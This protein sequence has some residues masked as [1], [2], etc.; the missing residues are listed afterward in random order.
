MNTTSSLLGKNF[1]PLTTENEKLGKLNSQMDQMKDDYEE[2]KRTREEAKKQLEAKF[3]DVYRKIQN[4]KDFIASEG[5]RINDT[6]IAFQSKFEFKM[7]TLEDKIQAQHEEHVNIVNNRF[8]EVNAG[9]TQLNQKI[10]EEKQER[11]KQSD[12]NLKEIRQQLG[13]LFDLYEKEKK[14]RIEKEKEIL[15]KLDDE[16]FFLNEKI[17]KETTERILKHKELRDDTNYELKQ[18]LKLN[19]D[20]HK[21]TIDEFTHIAVNLEKEMNNRFDHQD[22]IVDNL[23]NIVKTIQDTLK[24]IG[25]DV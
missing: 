20:F 1:K 16:K 15:Q 8:A 22:H 21:K 3:Q 9:L 14:E 25:K 5:K 24:I 4:T 23:S 18:Q 10:E 17:E 12:E 2:M 11:L 6:L 19:E 7:K 13:N